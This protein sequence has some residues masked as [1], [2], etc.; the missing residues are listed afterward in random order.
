MKA[1]IF[2]L[3]GVLVHTDCY[4]YLAW[5]KIS[6]KLG[7]CFNEQM[8]SRL[9]GVSRMESLEIVLETYQGPAISLEDKEE[10]A[11]EKNEYYKEYLLGM[12]AAD[13]EKPVRET[14]EILKKN[15]YKLAIGSSSKNARYILEKVEL[16]NYFDAV[17]D[18]TIINNSKPNPEVFLKAAYLLNVRPS[19]CA[20]VEDA[21]SG[22]DAAKAADMV[23]IAIGDA[24]RYGK[25]D[26]KINSIEELQRL[27]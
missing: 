26:I 8:N 11:R 25:A 23:A 18:G 20:V 27:I 16:L 17:S 22:I 2:D 24:K 9:R 21:C 4:H 14:L 5:K 6:D 3:D 10:L 13:V 15:N 1:F 12:T 19:E 7:I